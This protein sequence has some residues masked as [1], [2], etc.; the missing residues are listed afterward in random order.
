MPLN[1]DTII[2]GAGQAGLA[3]S[4]CLTEKRID[5]VVL[6]RGRVGERWLSE[7][8]PGLTLL[9]P[10]FMIRLPGHATQTD[11]DGFMQS[12]AFAGLL[13]SYGRAFAAPIRTACGVWS[14]TREG[15]RFVVRTTG[16][17]FAARA[18]VVATGACDQPAIPAWATALPKSIRQVTANQYSGPDALDD[19][20][21]LV[22]G[23]S[24]SGVQFAREIRASGRQVTIA[25][26]R[27]ARSPR[28]YR[29]RD[30]FYWLDRTGFLYEPRDPMVTNRRPVVLPSFQLTGSE[31]GQAIGLARLK[32][33]GVCITG[34][35]LG[36]SAGRVHFTS[37]IQEAMDAAEGRLQRLLSM[38]DQ[39]ISEMGFHAPQDPGAWERPAEIGG[40]PTELDLE[41]AGI[42]TIIW[43]T[44][45]RRSYPWLRLPVLSPEGEILQTD[46]ITPEP[47]LLTLGLPFMRHRSSAFI[48]GVDRDAEAI[49]AGVAAH[50]SISP[51]IAA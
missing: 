35:A 27:H 39:Y 17:D 31:G 10:N 42:R 36:V 34:R 37:S 12:D 51:S 45:F 48:Y 9:S 38:I 23:A 30:F 43:A 18:V 49:A 1:V 5:H 6:E 24:A 26:G 7:R 13:N 33:L 15:G 22:V 14:V 28:R 21:V 2:I 40:G 3:L 41:A 46:G 19:G 8:W 25:V 16:G 4:H 50:L 44:G 32:S 20:G 11:A 47:G 29:G